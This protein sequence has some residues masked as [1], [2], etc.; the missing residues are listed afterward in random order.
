MSGEGGWPFEDSEK[1]SSNGNSPKN[2]KLV[3]TKASEIP[4]E[5]VRWLWDTG[6]TLSERKGRIPVGTI[7]LVGG[8]PGTGKSQWTTWM[9]AQIS[10]GTLRGSTYGS[11]RSV[12]IVASEDSW[13][14]TV[15]PRLVA[16]DADLD[17]ILHIRP[18]IREDQRAY[19][20]LPDDLQELE[21][22]V[23]DYNVDLI[24]LDPLLSVL[25]PKIDDYK[26]RPVREALEPIAHMAE[27][28]EC[29]VLGIAHFTK[30]TEGKHLLQYL[31]GSGAYGQVVR[32][33]VA[34]AMGE[35]G[36]GVFTQAKNNLGRL[37]LPHWKYKI[38]PVDV[39]TKQGP[40]YV[41]K[42]LWTDEDSDLSV[43]E[44]LGATRKGQDP[45]RGEK[46]E[47]AER[48]VIRMIREMGPQRWE[49]LIE[50]GKKRHGMSEITMRRAR[51]TLKEDGTIDRRKKGRGADIR[52]EWF[53]CE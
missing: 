3:V 5:P 2:S 36:C 4:M 19:V 53:I 26:A 35:D 11:P 9:A 45:R 34:M 21:G 10:R 52:W 33:S 37:D 38:V 25:D 17:R 28:T 47:L 13:K 14:M 29:V 22:I 30:A 12:I 8:H 39:P 7:A 27:R 15:K 41:S 48:L 16:A 31:S 20:L 42:F 1:F 24:V 46:E 51:K 50:Q 43:E 40:A 49:V 6:T 44:I 18:A 23:I 32:S